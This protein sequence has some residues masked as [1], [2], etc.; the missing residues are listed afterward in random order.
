MIVG[1]VNATPDSFSDE[2]DRTTASFIENV[3]T[4]IE[5][6]AGIIEVGG[7][8]NVTN[9]PAVDAGEEIARI[10]PV[11]EAA[12]GLGAIVSIDTYKPEVAERALDAGAAIVNDISGSSREEMLAVCSS[13]GAGMVVMHTEVPPKTQKWDEALYPHGVVERQLEF[14]AER[15]E[16][17]ADAGIGPDQVILDPGP[18]FGKTPLQT[19]ESLRGIPALIDRFSRPVMLAVSRKDFVGALTNRRPRERAAG[20]LAAIGFGLDVGASLLRVH[21]VAG[22]ADY[23]KVREALLG[24]VE[25]SPELRIA[26]E[27][28]REPPGSTDGK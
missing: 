11:V 16:G 15:L 10:V 22:T 4:Q 14:F 9:R 17:L 23:L 24:E 3:T 6:G 25:V 7:E 1:V 5:A 28:R 2:G 19:I 13:W 27:V 26:D 8:S 21:D 18:D 20:T 12:V